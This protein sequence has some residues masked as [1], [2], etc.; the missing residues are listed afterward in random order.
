MTVP[1]V[2]IC[3]TL[4]TPKNFSKLFNEFKNFASQQ[5]KGTEN[6][7]NC[8]YYSIDEIRSINNLNHKLF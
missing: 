2:K 7:I 3:S 6:I 8:Y 4:K 5:N 1:L